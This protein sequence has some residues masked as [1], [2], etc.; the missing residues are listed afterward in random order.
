MAVARF[1]LSPPIPAVTM[2]CMTNPHRPSRPSRHHPYADAGST[3]AKPP[4]APSQAV[5]ARSRARVLARALQAV[6]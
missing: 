6:K 1:D 4:S 2:N 3:P 5:G